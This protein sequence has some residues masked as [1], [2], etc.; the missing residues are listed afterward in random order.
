MD[1]KPVH[2]ATTISV[3]KFKQ[4]LSM[5]QILKK[6]I[7]FLFESWWTLKHVLHIENTNSRLIKYNGTY[8]DITFLFSIKFEFSKT[9]IHGSGSWEERN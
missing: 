3:V 5:I 2:W 7:E 8:Y 4:Y 1:F 6:K 9:N